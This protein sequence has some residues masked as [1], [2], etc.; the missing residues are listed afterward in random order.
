MKK[1]IFARCIFTFALLCMITL[2]VNAASP[3]SY[4]YNIKTENDR[5]VEKV[6]FSE[7]GGILKRL[8]MYEFSYNGEGLVAEKKVHRWNERSEKWEPFYLM[9]YDYKSQDDNIKTHYVMWD[10]Q[11][12]KYC[13][14]EQY[15]LI[16]VNDYETIFS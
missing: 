6:V 14:Q 2:V 15:M 7:N 8:M 16:P 12:K 4:K 5:V 9:T 11:T 1:N 13:L 3:K 10:K